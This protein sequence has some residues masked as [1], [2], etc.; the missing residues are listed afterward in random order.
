MGAHKD[1]QASSRQCKIIAKCTPIFDSAVDP[2]SP[3]AYTSRQQRSNVSL[4]KAIAQQIVL[5]MACH[6]AGPAKPY[7]PAH[8]T[9]QHLSG[10]SQLPEGHPPSMLI[11]AMFIWQNGTFR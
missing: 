5:N 7:A 8:H 9:Y 10:R 1:N 2:V 3:R 4:G 11:N 6:A